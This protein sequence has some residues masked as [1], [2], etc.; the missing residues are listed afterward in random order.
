VRKFQPGCV[1]LLLLFG[2]LSVAEPTWAADNDSTWAADTTAASHLPV[3]A[4][5]IREKIRAGDLRCERARP[6]Y[7]T[8]SAG[9]AEYGY[10]KYGSEYRRDYCAQWYGPLQNPAQIPILTVNVD[11]SEPPDFVVTINTTHYQAGDRVFSVAAGLVTIIVTRTGKAPWKQT[12]T[13]TESGPNMVA[14]KL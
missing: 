8:K 9:Y 2:S 14:C 4:S 7:Q 5:E 1:S 13:V 11:P 3:M 6:E 10:G 12:L